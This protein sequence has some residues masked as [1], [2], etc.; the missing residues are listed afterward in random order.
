MYIEDHQDMWESLDPSLPLAY[1]SRPQQSTRVAPLENDVQELVRN[2]ALERVPNDPLP[3]TLPTT[4]RGARKQQRR[5]IRN[6][7]TQVRAAHAT[8]KRSYKQSSDKR[9]RP[10]NKAVKINDWDVVDALHGKTQ[11]GQQGGRPV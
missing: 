7:I 1:N 4:A 9:V 3:Q 8:P 11:V 6:L 5:N 10:V 2:V